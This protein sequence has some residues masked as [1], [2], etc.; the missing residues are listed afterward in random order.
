MIKEN[1]TNK[2]VENAQSQINNRTQKKK[3]GFGVK[4]G[5]RGNKIEMLNG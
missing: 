2:L 3:N 1:S 4:Y 5:E